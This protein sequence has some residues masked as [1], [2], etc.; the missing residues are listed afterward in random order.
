MPI[1]GP[2]FLFKRLR[3]LAFLPALVLLFLIC[4]YGVA[5]LHWD[6]WGCET[7]LL[8]TYLD[9]TLNAKAWLAQCNESRPVL[10]KVIWLILT[11]VSGVADPR[12]NMFAGWII[13]CITA[14]NIHKLGPGIGFTI[15]AS[16]LLFSPIQQENWL[17]GAQMMLFLPA[18]FLTT[19]LR[20]VGSPRA[21]LWGTVLAVLATFSFANGFLLWPALFAALG[22]IDRTQRLKASI[23]WAVALALS[24]ALY[25]YNFERVA[26]SPSYS[27]IFAQPLRAAQYFI[28]FLG[29]PLASGDL[30]RATIAGS[31]LLA[32][33][34]ILPKH[35][36]GWIILA[37]YALASAGLVTV[38]R[39][40][41]GPQQALDSRYGA[42]AVW[43]AIAVLA[44]AYESHW[45]W[46]GCLTIAILIAHSFSFWYG[47]KAMHYRTL[48]ARYQ[49]AC[50]T[51]VV[52]LPGGDCIG[53]YPVWSAD[54]LRESAVPLD[55]AGWITPKLM[56]S[57]ELIADA[58][59]GEGNLDV[60][61]AGSKWRLQG[62]VGV[63]ADAIVVAVSLGNGFVPVA[64]VQ[65]GR[66]IPLKVTP[67]AYRT[68]IDK[69][70]VPPG[71]RVAAFA[72]RAMD[73]R[74]SILGEPWVVPK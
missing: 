66:T 32:L 63:D 35:R 45:R 8:R 56:V 72:Y 6:E 26:S 39:V 50:L 13:V 4:H 7:P 14:W 3:P 59:P 30:T 27:A 65:P 55:K 21:I 69:A 51:F 5:S 25:L 58:V 44:L 33:F 67:S 52:A 68:E 9:G 10:P 64:V 48:A 73:P 40:A 53:N 28:S 54:F 29:N 17:W 20:V 34:A 62:G 22:L 16:A 19:W 43:I 46:R 70:L 31:L 60:V 23:T 61:D 57:G 74:W 71:A 37:G 18:L 2:E 1:P 49:R 41:L 11:V 47:V 38:G 15:L 24:L 12:W 36:V 42:F